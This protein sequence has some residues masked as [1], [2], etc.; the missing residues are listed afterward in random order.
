MSSAPNEARVE[1]TLGLS[2]DAR[3]GGQALPPREASSRGPRQY[4]ALL[5]G[6]KATL[7][8]CT[9]LDVQ[10]LFLVTREE[11]GGHGHLEGWP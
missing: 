9:A 8:C 5:L 11:E 7:L 1:R 3:V 6:H 4:H 2:V 10:R